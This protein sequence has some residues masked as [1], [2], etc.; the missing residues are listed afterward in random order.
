MENFASG[1][2]LSPER[3]GVQGNATR[4]KATRD[5][6]SISPLILSGGQSSTTL[7]SEEGGADYRRRGE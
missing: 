2:Q 6:L 1:S 3:E 7:S 5:D 4:R